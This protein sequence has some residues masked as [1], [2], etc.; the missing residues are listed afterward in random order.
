MGQLVA[1]FVGLPL[2]VLV[3]AQ[4][5]I[6]IQFQTDPVLVLSG[7]EILFTVLTVPDVLSMTWLYEDVTLGLFAGG[8][9]VLNEVAQFR[10][11]LTI[12]AT[13]LR[14]GSAQLG[15]A[16]TYTVEVIPLA[17]SGLTPNSRS[18]SLRVFDAVSEVTLS[19]PSVATEGGNVTLTC[20][21]S[22]TELT[23]QWGKDGE[24]ITEDGRITIAGGSLVINPGQRGDAGDYTCTVS[25]P[26][27]ART[28]TRSLTVFYGPDTP[29]L[30]KDA[31]K[32]CVG[33]VDVQ[34]GQTLRLTCLSDSLPPALFTWQRDGQPVVPAQPDSGVLSVQTSSTDDSGRYSCTARN[35]VT[36]GESV[37]GTDVSVENT[38]LDVGE[39]V[40]IVIGSFLLLLILVLL[41]VLLVCLVLRRRARQRQGEVITVQKNRTNPQPQ[42]PDPR[43]NLAMDPTRNPDPPVFQWSPRGRRPAGLYAGQEPRPT[44]LQALQLNNLQRNGLAPELLGELPRNASSYPLDGFDN[45][46]FSRADPQRT[47][48]NVVLQT[49][50]GQSDGRPAGVQLNLTQGSQPN[51]PMPTINVNLNTFP[52]Q[53]ATNRPI[54]L[55]DTGQSNPRMPSG[56]ASQGLQAQPGL[57]PTGYTHS[58]TAQ[59]NART[60]T[61]QQEVSAAGSSHRQMSW[62]LLRGTPAYPRGTLPRGLAS[63]TTDYTD[64][65]PLRQTQPRSRN[66]FRED[67]TSTVRQGRTRNHSADFWDSR[68]LRVPQLEPAN[69]SDRSPTTQRQ[70]AR[71][72][73][74]LSSATQSS[75]SQDTTTSSNPFV[76]QQATFRQSNPFN[77]AQA[78]PNR[79]RQAQAVQQQ[80]AALAQ[81]A[82]TRSTSQPRQAN[83][84]EAD[85]LTQAAL[86]SHTESA[87]VF[88]NRR[89][90]T[91]AALFHPVPRAQ[92]TMAP[93]GPRA[94]TPPPVIPLAQFQSLP[95]AHTRHKSKQHRSGHGGQHQHARGRA[96]TRGHAGHSRTVHGHAVHG[97]AAHQ[98]QH[99]AHRSR[100]R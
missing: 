37:R 85:A 19:V 5:P 90:Q 16:G 24:A 29:V 20:T 25:N 49:G 43:A 27:S 71:Q 21:A 69:H 2:A 44:N 61:Y 82:Q 26:V 64:H 40:G 8:S 28:A 93:A 32:D 88:Q 60:Q 10:G 57:I 62:D 41:I 12:T 97:H 99:Q 55:T 4:D 50:P 95:R 30:T 3:L 77:S 74:R 67:A 7:T 56:S 48:S 73:S 17:S 34:A 38:C 6:Q 45:P 94:P 15:D 96:H 58:H 39:V 75:S 59:R 14:I 83:Q 98:Q 54:Q 92:P 76:S 9:P 100:P 13:Q 11:R 87:K 68:T 79:L 89:Q 35:A 91:Q 23:F 42:P 81:A 66:P 70:Q 36:G 65:P 72:D 31:P 52:Q 51:V 86:K 78:D 33:S 1:F 22:G 80:R 63:D 47:N 46:A 53:E 84:R 18:V